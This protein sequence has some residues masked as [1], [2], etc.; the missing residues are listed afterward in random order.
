MDAWMNAWMH[1]WM[2]YE[3]GMVGSVEVWR[4]WGGI[5]SCEVEIT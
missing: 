4:S 5:R 2:E 3:V 1:E